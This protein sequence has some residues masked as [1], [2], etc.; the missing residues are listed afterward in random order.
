MLATILVV[1]AGGGT[2]TFLAPKSAL[3]QGFIDM[4]GDL[5]NI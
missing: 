1:A 4:S 2:T 3:A 5:S